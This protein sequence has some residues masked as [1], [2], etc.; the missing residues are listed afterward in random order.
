MKYAQVAL[1]LPIDKLFHYRIPDTLTPQ[2]EEGKRIWVPFRNRRMVGFVVGLSDSTEV[3]ETKD[4][5]GVIEDAPILNKTMLSLTKWLSQYY[6]CSWGEAIALALPGLIKRGRIKAQPRATTSE[7]DHITWSSYKRPSSLNPE[8]AEALAA[9]KANLEKKNFGV[10]LLYGATGS[11]KTEVYIQAI[12]EVLRAGRSSIVLVPEISLTPQTVGRFRSRFGETVALLHSR[13]LETE[14][15]LQWQR[16]KEGKAKIVVGARS[17]VFAPVSALGLIVVDEEHDT[18]YKQDEGPR[19]NAR[20]VAIM[21]AQLEGATVILGSATPSLESFH[22]THR[23]KS[24]LLM[25]RERVD[26]KPMPE[27]QIVDM[28]QFDRAPGKSVVFSPILEEDIGLRLSR[29]EQVMLFLN[30]RGFSTFINCRKC[31]YVLKCRACNVSLAYHSEIDRALC[32]YCNV[33]VEV[34]PICPNCNGAYIKHFGIGTQKVES[35]AHRLFA[36]ANIARMDADT[37]ARRGSHHKILTD[38]KLGKIDILIGTQMIAKGHDF[39]RVTLVGVIFADSSLNIPDLRAS[40]RTFSLL[41]QM[42]GRTGRGEKQ[43]KVIVQTYDPLHYA[44]LAVQGH[45]YGTFF[46]QELKF[47]E[48][49]AYPPF[50]YMTSLILRSR[51]EEKVIGAAQELAAALNKNNPG[52]TVDLLGPAPMMIS[53]LRGYFRWNIILKSKMASHINKLIRQTLADFK[54]PSGVLLAVDVDPL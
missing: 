50:T 22:N 43:G 21:R 52:G 39:P 9:I 20:D 42:A 29:K 32:H 46:K 2:V 28:R 30:R 5:Q 36:T 53:R 38:F 13:L 14:R 40:E 19:Y 3:K 47:R 31:G 18:S 16:I 41:A 1:A 10:F 6:H 23:N 12:E 35:E 27:V 25:L 7:D 15:F 24:K 26:K 44:I 11:G 4:I 8:Q 45:D 33:R 37:T 54:M 34:P 48:E 17:A 49:L 51:R